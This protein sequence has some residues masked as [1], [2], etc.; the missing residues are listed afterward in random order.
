MKIALVDNFHRFQNSAVGR[1]ASPYTPE[2]GSLAYWRARILFSVLFTAL[3]L[4]VFA[5]ISGISVAI[6]ENAWGL[7]LFDCFGYLI[8]VYLIMSR[9]LRYEI[10]ASITLMMCYAVGIVVLL[11]V[12]PLS[13]GAAWLFAFA[14]LVAVL[15]GFKPAI[16]AILL[17]ASS[18]S[19]IAWLILDK[20]LDVDFSF[21]RTT[22]A[23]VA[24]GV[25]FVVLN[26]IAAVSVASLVKGLVDTYEKKGAL[27][28]NLEQERMQ[29]TEAKKELESEIDERKQ[30]EKALSESEEKYKGLVRHAPAGIF[31]FDMQKLKLISVN[32]VMCQYT[33]YSEK[34]FLKLD[35]FEILG[36]ASK[37]TL[38]ELVEDVFSNQPKELSTEF[39]I[40]AK[41]Q[42]EYRVLVNSKFFYED[43]IPKRAMAVVHDLT[44]IR[45]AEEEKRKLETQ[46]QNAKKLESLGTLAGGVA[47]DL[48]NILSGVVSY[49]DLLLLD[50]EADSPL[51]GPLLAIKQSG[52]KAAEIVQDLLT[53]ARRGVASSKVIDLNQVVNDFM[54]SPEYN[55]ILMPH[56]NIRIETKLN[57]DVFNIIGSEVHICKTL[58]NLVANAVDAMPAGGKVIIA[59]KSCYLDT[60]YS[61]YESIPEGEYTTLEIS[62][63]GIGIAQSDLER[64]FEPFY[65]KK[66]MGRSGTGLG[67]SVVWGTVK[68]HDGYI[69]IV[70]EEGS[71]TTFTLYFPTSRSELQTTSTV[72]IEDYLG[73]GES[74]LIVDD[75]PEQRVLAQRM[76]E[77][78]G[79][80]VYTAGSGEEAVSLV[81]KR[82]Y[83]LLI[84]DMIMPPGMDGLETYKKILEIVPEQKAVIASGYAISEHV[85]K[86]QQMGAGGY[87][88]KPFTLEKIGLA[89]RAELD[90]KK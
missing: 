2:Y 17:N 47:H 26:A 15:L 80:E 74:I 31:E 88:K 65:T 33:G 49:P 27:A 3:I 30:A 62:D 32:D 6:K 7:L 58:M 20:K 71:G 8:G 54:V 10:R 46:L 68:D 67:M 40:R 16:L 35:P 89:V 38:N 57:K 59:S 9:R 23:M 63:M 77:R 64:I 36:D 84:L 81:N 90:Q 28:E 25:N 39:S 1:I 13:G 85:H 69:D 55:K 48:N 70:T 83:D 34:E 24:A 82:Q 37:G 14:V 21:F 73:K 43:G 53:L 42:R 5:T 66:A 22:Q 61:G 18:L 78:L 44:N 50:L 51:R 52:E 29:L 86:A 12:G 11:S 19:I 87:I 79:Y 75:S 72:Y 45:R 60:E 56:E 4:G 76:I 41:N